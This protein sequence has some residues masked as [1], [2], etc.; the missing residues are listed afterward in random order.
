MYEERLTTNAAHELCAGSDSVRTGNS[1]IS[2]EHY[3][4]WQATM[5]SF[6]LPRWREHNMFDEEETKTLL[7]LS[8]PTYSWPLCPLWASLLRNLCPRSKSSALVFTAADAVNTMGMQLPDDNKAQRVTALCLFICFAFHCFNFHV[9]VCEDK[10]GVITISTIYITA[11]SSKC[12][13]YSLRH[14]HCSRRSCGQ[15][16]YS[17]TER[18]LL[19]PPAAVKRS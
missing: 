1:R 10:G 12:L 18:S 7:P 9:A 3:V 6:F 17:E 13:C 14:Q 8:W 16:A 19:I 11:I 15:R 4:I 2:K 5:F